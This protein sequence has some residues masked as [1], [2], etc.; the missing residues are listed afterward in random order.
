MHLRP[1]LRL[2]VAAVA[3]AA[4]ARTAAAQVLVTSSSVEEHQARPG[5]QW[6]GVI[7]LRNTTGTPQDVRVYLSDYAFQADGTTTYGQ[8][9][10]SPRS[11]ARWT[12]VSPSRVTVPANGEATVG[13]T[14]AVP[15][16]AA[17][18][19]TYWSMVMV[20]GISP[21]GAEAAVARSARVRIGVR[22]TIR[23]GVQ[24][25]T[26]MAG[27]GSAK[28]AFANPH[29]EPAAAGHRTLA[30]DLANQGDLGFRPKVRL[31]LFDAAGSSVGRWEAA[32]GLLYP[33]S[34]LRQAFDLGAL[35]AGTYQALVV[36]DAGGESVFGARYRLSL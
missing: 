22:P 30:F 23:Y 35:P 11:S 29:A 14:V 21:E 4:C 19:G 28:A 5:E 2:S 20:E 27:T 36:A 18:T 26:T 34:S 17:L 33:G 3:A 8:P 9:G 13:Y 15:A 25:A 1:F 10:S 6:S 7:R 31:E 32:R 24:I 16:G 12:T